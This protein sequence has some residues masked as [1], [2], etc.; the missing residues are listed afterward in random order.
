[1]T[2]E[3]I[4]SHIVDE[5]EAKAAEAAAK[6]S[7]ETE[8]TVSTARQEA[9]AGYADGAERLKAELAGAFDQG[10]GQLQSHERLEMLKV[11]TGILDGLFSKATEKLLFDDGF[12]QLTRENLKKVAAQK[13]AIACREDHRETIGKMIDELNAGA[14]GKIPALADDNVD[15]LGGFIFLGDTFDIDFSL[16]SQ[17]ETFRTQV[18]PELMAEAFPEQ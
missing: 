6:T 11:K 5:A 1:M 16:D 14:G 13:G 15:I 17:L 10:V 9:E 12:W 2:L 18:L 3:K 4:E 8:R 7:E